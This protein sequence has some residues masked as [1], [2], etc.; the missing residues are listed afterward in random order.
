[1]FPIVSTEDKK[2]NQ[3]IAV[4]KRK[5]NHIIDEEQWKINQIIA[6][7]KRKM[8]QIKN[9]CFVTSKTY[10]RNK[11]PWLIMYLTG[12]HLSKVGQKFNCLIVPF[13]HS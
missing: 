1:M 8:K 5:T 3:V 12:M 7:E 11:R 6:E 2:I 4:E 9:G 13:L 10:D